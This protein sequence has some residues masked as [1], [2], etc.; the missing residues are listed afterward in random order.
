MSFLKGTSFELSPK[1]LIKFTLQCLVGYHETTLCDN[2][3]APYIMH[4]QEVSCRAS[5][6]I[7]FQKERESDYFHFLTLLTDDMTYVLGSKPS[8]TRLKHVL[9][10]KKKCYDSCMTSWHIIEKP[11]KFKHV[12]G[13]KIP[14]NINHPFPH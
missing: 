3:V 6:K 14:H 9:L 1:G 5:S 7:T 8:H 10:Q 2:H 12:M 4:R 13:I 11:Q